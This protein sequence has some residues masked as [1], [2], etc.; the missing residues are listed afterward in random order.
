[1]NAYS[2]R[3]FSDTS[4]ID[5]ATVGALEL[6]EQCVDQYGRDNADDA[7]DSL[8]YLWN[9]Y[10]RQV[11]TYGD[12][13]PFTASAV[14]DVQELRNILAKLDQDEPET[15]ASLTQLM[16]LCGVTATKTDSGPYEFNLDYDSW[17]QNQPIVERVIGYAQ[18]QD[19]GYI[20]TIGKN[21]VLAANGF[22]GLG[23]HFEPEVV[24]KV[25]A[26]FGIEHKGIL[27][28]V[29]NAKETAGPESK[30]LSHSEYLREIARKIYV[31]PNC[32]LKAEEVRFLYIEAPFIC[33]RLEDE[34]KGYSH[35]EFD[36]MNRFMKTTSNPLQGDED[37][38]RSWKNT[39]LALSHIR[40]VR[41]EN[42]QDKLALETMMPD[43]LREQVSAAYEA[44]KTITDGYNEAFAA[45]PSQYEATY[46]KDGE[47][48]EVLGEEAFKELFNKKLESWRENGTIDFMVNQALKE[49]YSHLL[50]AFPQGNIYG[51]ALYDSAAKLSHGA[52]D[53]Y[54]CGHADFDY[55]AQEDLKR[56]VSNRSYAE[57][58]ARNHQPIDAPVEFSLMAS[59]RHDSDELPQGAPQL[60]IPNFAETLSYWLRLDQMGIMKE[61][62]YNYA[63]DDLGA[64][65]LSTTVHAGA[66]DRYTTVSELRPEG[67]LGTRSSYVG[68]G[69]EQ[70]RVSIR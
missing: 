17:R 34:R 53:L 60:F 43:V 26:E 27:E 51:K 39:D 2:G 20:Q 30:A 44:Y 21:A 54:S 61:G 18:A 13:E 33:T 59:R 7:L 68:D 28:Y 24:D 36:D 45:K 64:V 50:T 40:S 46:G 23:T 35:D 3:E 12:K 70:L 31:N 15:R 52:W 69:S 67:T 22:V 48:I 6:Y 58:R 14:A 4:F 19:S 42:E 5:P 8:E 56:Q 63:K 55:D 9:S 66:I 16:S 25:A 11:S 37:W 49:G 41:G 10:L 57:K 62:A 32:E 47:P 65:V 38:R 1:M 29:V